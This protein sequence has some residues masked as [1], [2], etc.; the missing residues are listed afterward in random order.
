MADQITDGR[1]LLDAADATTNFIGSTSPAQDTEIFIQGTA[2]VAEQLT[3]SLRYVMYDAGTPQDWTNNVFYIWINCGVV[4]LLDTKALGGFRIRFAG[5]T[6]T[7]FFE[8]Y[9]GG[10]DSWPVSIAGGWTLFVVD[11]DQASRYPSNTGGTPPGTNAIQHVGWAGVTGGTMTRAADNTWMDAL[12]RLPKGDPGILIEGVNSGVSPIRAWNAQDIFDTLGNAA[13]TFVPVAGGGF[14]VAAPIQVGTSTA[15][16]QAETHQFTDSNAIL[17][18]DDQEFIGEDFYAIDVRQAAGNTTQFDFTGGVIAAGD[19]FGDITRFQVRCPD[20]DVNLL[21]FNGTTFVHAGAL[22]FDVN[23][24]SVDNCTLSD[25]Q[26]IHHSQLTDSYDSN[27]HVAPAVRTGEALVMTDRINGIT[28][29]S[30]EAGVNGGH[31]IETW[32]IRTLFADSFDPGPGERTNKSD[33]PVVSPYD[34]YDISQHDANYDPARYGWYENNGS[35]TLL[36]IPGSVG[37]QNRNTLQEWISPPEYFLNV[38]GSRYQ[39]IGPIS[40][41]GT[42]GVGRASE[43]TIDVVWSKGSDFDNFFIMLRRADVN[44]QLVIEHDNDSPTGNIQIREY[45][46]GNMLTSPFLAEGNFAQIFSPL[47]TKMRTRVELS[48]NTITVYAGAY[49]PFGSPNLLDQIV[50]ATLQDSPAPGA[51][52]GF[53]AFTTQ[54]CKVHAVQVRTD[55]GVLGDISSGN[56]FTG[57]GGSPIGTNSV[58]NAGSNDAVVFNRRRGIASI[59]VG[60]GGATPSVRNDVGTTTTVTNDVA[61]TLTGLRETTEV[62]VLNAG[63]TTVLSEIENVASPTDYT[64]TVGSG[65]AVDIVIHAIGFE[66]IRLENLSFTADTTLPITQRVDRNY[67]NP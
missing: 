62:T 52:L 46:A 38:Q 59:A 39:P 33:S 9:V 54:G 60:G 37:G 25:V 41:V 17:L 5:A 1:T 14:K 58:P 63:T 23:G 51:G 43:L 65:V 35:P 66:H 22:F 18:W 56:V 2:S 4:G 19:D 55:A 29:C 11:I 3:S 30:F 21:S 31:A 15:S 24:V 48:G 67:S 61:V 40:P 20:G 53:G 42:A 10:N 26:R 47:T 27:S 12:Y 34:G 36:I 32:G 50:T 44:N 45:S 13:G 7:D 28:N 8:V 57:Y 6:E 49:D 64:F 16:P